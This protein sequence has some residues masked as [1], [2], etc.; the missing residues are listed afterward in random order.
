[1]LSLSESIQKESQWI[2]V[3]SKSVKDSDGFYTDYTL[4]KSTPEGLWITVFGD[5][6]F[7]QPDPDYADFSSDSEKEAREFF[8]NFQ[9]FDDEDDIKESLTEAASES[10]MIEDSTDPQFIASQI[11][12]NIKGEWDAIEGYNKLIPFFENVNDQD[13]ID[14]IEEIISDE[15]HHS[16]I[17]SELLFKYDGN[18]PV[19]ED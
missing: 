8:D 15:K 17:L 12:L 5:K 10:E 9:G 2:E 6:E 16:M 14:M 3:K 4:Y 7:Y 13:A 11:S 1:M 19:A 18:I